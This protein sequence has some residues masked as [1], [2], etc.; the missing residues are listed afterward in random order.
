MIVYKIDRQT[1]AS[2]STQIKDMSV[3]LDE[4]A[5]TLEILQKLLTEHGQSISTPTIDRYRI[6]LQQAI[7]SATKL[8]RDIAEKAQQLCSVSDQ[9]TKHLASIDEHF[10]AVL[11]DQPSPAAQV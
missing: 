7:D 5:P 1:Q 11:R 6:D 3:V 2:A 4:M 9:A 8:N 10:G